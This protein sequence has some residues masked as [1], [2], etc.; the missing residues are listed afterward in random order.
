M[1]SSEADIRAVLTWFKLYPP[2]HAIRQSQFAL[3][4]RV[5]HFKNI[6][7][8]PLNY[9]ASYAWPVL[10]SILPEWYAI[11]NLINTN[12]DK[13]Y[14]TLRKAEHDLKTKLN[15]GPNPRVNF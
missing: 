14:V 2:V 7:L 1:W 13:T 4:G 5:W 11:G 6:G 15:L 3:M 12:K 10:N 8:L 9:E